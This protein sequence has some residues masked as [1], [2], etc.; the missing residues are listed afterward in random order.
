M[1]GSVIQATGLAE[2]EDGLK[3]LNQSGARKS[4]QMVCII[5]EINDNID[6]E[7]GVDQVPPA[8]AEQ[9]LI[10]HILRTNDILVQM[11]LWY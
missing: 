10:Y 3:R 2:L 6:P 11:L 1:A 8:G 5:P 7:D 4:L 9:H